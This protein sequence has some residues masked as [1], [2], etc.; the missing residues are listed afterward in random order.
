MNRNKDKKIKLIFIKINV[1]AAY[2]N[3]FKMIINKTKQ[4]I[5]NKPFNN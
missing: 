5:N 3:K 1:N 4:Q 2:R